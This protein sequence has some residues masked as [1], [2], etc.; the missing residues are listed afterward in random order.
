MLILESTAPV[1]R[2][3]LPDLRKP[4]IYTSIVLG[5]AA[6]VAPAAFSLSLLQSPTGTYLDPRPQTEM[7]QVTPPP[8]DTPAS[9]QTLVLSAQAYLEKAIDLSKQTDQTEEDRQKIITL[10]NQS[11]DFSNQAVLAAPNAPQTYLIRARVLASST[12][13]RPDALQ[14]AQKDLEIAQRLSGGEKVSLPTQVN[15]LQLSP[16]QQAALAQNLIIAAPGESSTSADTTS[17]TSSNIIKNQVT[18]KAGTDHVTIFDDRIG[19]ASYLYIINTTDSTPVYI[20]TK[21]NGEAVIATLDKVA[22]HLSLEYWL[23]LP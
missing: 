17:E 4:L 11:L 20:K 12:S 2:F 9:P 21:G 10:L 7:A 1:R 22:A 18:L 19:P 23:V 14:L 13:L 16:T 6:L 5:G 3:V 15:L 8:T